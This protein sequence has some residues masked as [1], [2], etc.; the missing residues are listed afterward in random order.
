LNKNSELK[1]LLMR[2]RAIANDDEPKPVVE[3]LLRDCL[4]I[5]HLRDRK[6]LNGLWTIYG[7]IEV[8]HD[9]GRVEQIRIDW[10][11]CF[12]TRRPWLI[13]P[14]CGERA[15]RLY[16]RGGGGYRCRPCCKAVYQCQMI[17]TRKRWRHKLEILCRRAGGSHATPGG[18]VRRQRY[19]TI[20]KYSQ[21]V[22]KARS[23][24]VGCICAR[25]SVL[26]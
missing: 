3:D 9:S 17:S 6:R 20:G 24:S 8:H 15:Q 25:I 19:M 2:R 16:N 23:S 4:A 13:C 21:V 7:G 10:T 1:E 22:R 26:G 14:T 18:Q 5:D 12:N 11:P